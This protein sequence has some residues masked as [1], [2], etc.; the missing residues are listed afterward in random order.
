MKYVLIII[1]FLNF[2]DEI[3]YD[4]CSCNSAIDSLT[5]KYFNYNLFFSIDNII[6]A[7]KKVLPKIN[8]QRMVS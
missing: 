6:D 2:V 5:S 8:V 7:L 3:Y 4:Q 1:I